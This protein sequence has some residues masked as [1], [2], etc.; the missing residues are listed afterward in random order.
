MG[1]SLKSRAKAGDDGEILETADAPDSGDELVVI[2]WS[3]SLYSIVKKI[4]G[5]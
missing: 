3:S 2:D 1:G 4:D 5:G